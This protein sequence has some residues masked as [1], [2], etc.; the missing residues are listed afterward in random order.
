M[1]LH[2]FEGDTVQYFLVD[3]P[4]RWSV[5]IGG[6]SGE[7]DQEREAHV[8]SIKPDSFFSA[9]VELDK[10]NAAVLERIQMP[11]FPDPLDIDT[12]A[13]VAWEAEFWLF[14]RTFGM[15]STIDVYCVRTDGK[16]PRV[17]KNI[18][19]NVAGVGVSTCA[20]S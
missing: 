16:M 18:G 8:L 20:L 7:Q 5:V 15:G 3:W 12:S 11:V 17:R 14:V 13:F 9:L 1:F 19:I 10:D 6:A 2:V 4:D